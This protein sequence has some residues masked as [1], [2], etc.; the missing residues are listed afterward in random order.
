MFSAY[1]QLGFHHIANLNA[2]D[3]LVFILAMASG[4]SF[5]DWKKLGILVTAFTV[6]HSLTLA[7]A[8]LG[9]VQPDTKVV[10]FL[11][12]VTILITAIY[13]LLVK[14][15]KGSRMLYF[16]VLF[17][18]LIHGLGFSNFLRQTLSEEQSLVVPL[19]SFNIGLEL[20]QLLILIIFLLT[21]LLFTR[22]FKFP[23]KDWHTYIC[24]IAS[25]VSIVLMITTKFW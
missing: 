21:G 17:F 2:Y 22:L 6:G 23:D 18:G 13:S 15:T 5:S 4:Y 3:H 10:E 8:T 7:L 14:K 19:L 24:G 1:L 20:G 12:P 11:I 16:S 9:W 25:G